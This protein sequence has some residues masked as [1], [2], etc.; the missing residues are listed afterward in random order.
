MKC[1]FEMLVSYLD[2]KLGLDDQIAVLEH[3]DLCDA[4]FDAV[5]QL[6][7]DRD[8]DLFVKEPEAVLAHWWGS[9]V[10]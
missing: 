6:S 5:Y 1:D 3:L 7:R 2:N 10:S 4:C 9:R 8:A